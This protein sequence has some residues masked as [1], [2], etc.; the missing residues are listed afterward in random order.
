MG[1][2][3]C[4]LFPLHVDLTHYFLKIKNS[5]KD[6]LLFI[7][8][9]HLVIFSANKKVSSADIPLKETFFR[10]YFCSANHAATVVASSPLTMPPFIWP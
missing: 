9:K 4:H 1:G 7:P 3:I 5:I 6:R 10:H 8:E 2:L